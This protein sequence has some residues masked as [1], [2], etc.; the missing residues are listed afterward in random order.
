MSIQIDIHQHIW[1]DAL[2]EALTERE[3][4]PFVRRANGLTVVHSAGERP[5][6]VDVEAESAVHRAAL[7]RADG[8]ELAVLALSSPIGIEALPRGDAWELI[9]AHLDG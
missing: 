8:V 3:A 4:L 2:L 6:V 7:L 9:S 1:T 5:Y